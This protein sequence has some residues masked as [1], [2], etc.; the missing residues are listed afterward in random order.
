[1]KKPILTLILLIVFT[2]PTYAQIFSEY[3]S[4]KDIS[5][6]IKIETTNQQ[7]AKKISSDIFTIITN[8]YFKYSYTEDSYISEIT[9]QAYKKFVRIDNEFHNMLS[10]IIFYQ[11]RTR[12]I[13]PILG[14]LIDIWGFEKGVL[15]I[16]TKEEISNAL[17]ISSPRNLLISSNS[18]AL[19]DKRTKFYLKPFALGL[20]I[21]KAENY[22]KD[23]K[24]TNAFISIN[25]NLSLCIGNKDGFGWSI[26]I[27]NPINRIENETLLTINL[28][29]TSI[30]TASIT[31]NAFIE[32]F[33]TYHSIIDPKTGYPPDNNV[34]SVSVIHKDPLEAIILARIILVLGKDAGMK[35]AEERKLT[36]LIT[37]S[38]RNRTQIYKTSQWIKTFDKDTTKKDKVRN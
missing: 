2:K 17:R 13:S 38:E 29:N 37:T 6:I 25:N 20:A 36:A 7:Y 34:S 24:I 12:A 22:L 23:N 5:V 31:E 3:I 14:Y 11:N 35:F 9:K 26:G 27:L 15:Y 4:Q 30:Y 21:T 8:E 32:G 1:M 18:I 10:R 16:P 33:K 19:R 28:S